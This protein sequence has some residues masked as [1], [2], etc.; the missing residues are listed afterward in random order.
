MNWMFDTDIMI[1]LINRR[2]GFER[3]ARRMSGRSPGELKVSAITV[4]ELRF[5][6]ANGE[7]RKENEAALDELLDLFEMDDLPCGAAG[8]FGEI[9]T[10]LLS[11]GKPIGPYDMLIASH[12][13][14]I[15]ATVVTNNEREFRRVPGLA[16]ENWLKP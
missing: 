14:H 1:H 12:A 7:F 15:G 3:I 8:D 2:P 13:R 11:K 16:V 9:K 6:A 4:A 10:A 5:G